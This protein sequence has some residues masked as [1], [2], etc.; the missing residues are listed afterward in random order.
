MSLQGVAG[1]GLMQGR[2]SSTQG[3][4][5]ES[6]VGATKEECR[7]RLGGPSPWAYRHRGLKEWPE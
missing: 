2:V 5:Q 7:D 6:K 1:Q 3:C 4:R